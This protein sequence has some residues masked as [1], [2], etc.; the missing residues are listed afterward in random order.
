MILEFKKLIDLA[1]FKQSIGIW[2]TSTLS[3][4]R[5]RASSRA[6]KHL[7]R[8]ALLWPTRFGPEVGQI[9]INRSSSLLTRSSQPTMSTDD[10]SVASPRRITYLIDAI[11]FV[12][13]W[14]PERMY[15]SLIRAQG[16]KSSTTSRV[17]QFRNGVKPRGQPRS[18]ACSDKARWG[19]ISYWCVTTL[20]YAVSML[21]T[22]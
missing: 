3:R 11:V 1:S 10:A 6:S 18:L 8:A 4:P 13:R 20:W 14:L 5:S 16:H 19:C 12:T 22:Y 17:G 9:E 2:G 7:G 15:V 21:R